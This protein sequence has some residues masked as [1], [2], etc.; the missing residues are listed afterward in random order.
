MKKYFLLAGLVALTVL[1][2]R[3]QYNFVVPTPLYGNVS[4]SCEVNAND[5]SDQQ[6]RDDVKRALF[7]LSLQEADGSIATCSG[8]LINRNTSQGTL[9][10]YFITAWHC[11]K[12]GSSGCGGDQFDF[13]NQPVTFYFNYQSP[14]NESGQVFSQN[15]SGTV[16]SITRYVQLVDHVECAYGDFAICQILGDPIPPYFNVYYAG[17][18]PTDLLIDNNGP[19]VEF[20]HPGGDI[21][22]ATQFNNIS[23][24]S[25]NVVATACKVVTKLIDF[26]FGWIWGHRWS[27]ETVCT[28]L[29]VPFVGTRYQAALPVFGILEDGSSGGGLLTGQN[30]TAGANRYIG[31]LSGTVP[32]FS[33]SNIDLGIAFYS[34]LSDSYYRQTVK[35]TLNPP[36]DYWVDQGGIAGRQ[37]TCYPQITLD[38]TQNPIN[39]YPSSLYSDNNNIVLTS[40]S[41]ITINGSNPVVVKNGA[42]FTFQAA[43][44][45]TLGPGFS[46]EA[47][48][49]FTAI[50]TSTPCTIDGVAKARPPYKY[51]APA[52]VKF[53]DSTA[54]PIQQKRFDINQFLPASDSNSNITRFV[55]YPNPTSGPVR[56]DLFFKD[57]EPSVDMTLYDVN[58]KAV[59][60]ASYRNVYFLQEALPLPNLAGGLYNL[61]VRTASRVESRRVVIAN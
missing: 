51:A 52:R 5:R 13:T 33:C 46:V 57:Q 55:V 26:L 12:S 1:H 15:Q 47:G 48:A 39:L 40:Q 18:Y 9:G 37:I 58:G 7:K 44:S 20:H 60:T 41:T 14:P 11:F 25:G 22:K 17:W 35:N 42:D 30:G 31:H 50:A 49:N 32:N 61:T 2:V 21:K 45:I 53:M 43:T 28:Y 24:G 3:A 16:Y 36:N 6:F 27:T 34:R 54:A 29:E 56:V 19:F 10:E 4:A 8:T 38:A 23:V 59:Y